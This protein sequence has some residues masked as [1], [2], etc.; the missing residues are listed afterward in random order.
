MP[1]PAWRGPHLQTDS[2]MALTRCT[3]RVFGALRL[4]ACAEPASSVAG[5]C[6]RTTP[7][8]MT[9]L[10]YP[11]NLVEWG[12]RIFTPTLSTPFEI[13]GLIDTDEIA[14]SNKFKRLQP[15]LLNVGEK[16]SA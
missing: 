15:R 9:T 16:S 11:A 1:D 2:P 13:I 3:Q 6:C 8:A 4:S 12:N 14:L 7:D 5:A 10:C